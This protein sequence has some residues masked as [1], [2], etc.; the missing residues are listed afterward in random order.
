MMWAQRP[1]PFEVDDHFRVFP[2]R[3]HAF[4]IVHNK[5]AVDFVSGSA[6]DRAQNF[7]RSSRSIGFRGRLRL[8]ARDFTTEEEQ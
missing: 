7:E 8:T 6:G 2:G 1:L 4:R 3:E 5:T